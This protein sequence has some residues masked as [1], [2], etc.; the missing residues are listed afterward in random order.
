MLR[1]ALFFGVGVLS[2]HFLIADEEILITNSIV[3]ATVPTWLEAIVLD[4]NGNMTD[5][6]YL[7]N[8]STEL[9]II[10]SN[11]EGDNASIFFP[12]FSVGFIWWNGH[13]VNL[14]GYYYYDDEAYWFLDGYYFDTDDY[15]L[16]QVKHADW[17]N[18]WNGYWNNHWD[19]HWH[20]YWNN[21]R[22]DQNFQ[23]HNQEQWLDRSF[24]GGWR[25]ETW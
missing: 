2:A 16:V 12:L 10:N 18:Y 24:Q 13:W 17:N 6:Q 1:K 25:R 8:P 15:P 21:H 23:Y 14:D 20:N 19:N 9:M 5:Q 11:T 7:Y 3:K 4:A 22:Q